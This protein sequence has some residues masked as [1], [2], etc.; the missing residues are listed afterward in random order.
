MPD[1]KK[2]KEA[3]KKGIPSELRGI[4]WQ[5]LVSNDL[6]ITNKLYDSL[7]ERAKISEQ[8]AERDPFFR[9]NLKV[10]EEDL[11]R[12]FGELGHFRYGNKLY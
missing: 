9:K 8:N 5:E 4:V 10:I 11:H 2:F 1:E 7:L 12:T 6:R 3:L